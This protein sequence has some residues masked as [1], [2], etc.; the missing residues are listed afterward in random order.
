MPNMR[1]VYASGAEVD[2]ITKRMDRLS[3]TDPRVLNRLLNK[4]ETKTQ[5]ATIM[6]MLQKRLP[7]PPSILTGR[8]RAPDTTDELR[9]FGD[10]E[11]ARHAVAERR[12]SR[13]QVAE[14]RAVAKRAREEDDDE[15]LSKVFATITEEA[16]QANVD[17][18]TKRKA[19]SNGSMA[20][21]LDSWNA[22]MQ[23]VRAN[24]PSSVASIAAS[25]AASTPGSSMVPTPQKEEDE[26]RPSKRH[27][28]NVD[29]TRL[30]DVRLN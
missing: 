28:T 1:D 19:P 10:D 25:K 17:A 18:E 30:R 5:F 29:P 26:S 6:D 20:A 4:Q 13:D 9:H 16:L 7:R 8:R 3:A 24:T 21:V 14:F 23:K 22:V 15:E 11:G 2:V 27:A 12:M